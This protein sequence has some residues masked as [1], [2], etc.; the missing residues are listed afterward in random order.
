MDPAGVSREE[1]DD[2]GDRL[3]AHA[4]QL[5]SALRR[6]RARA[7]RA[8]Y[9]PQRHKR[10]LAEFSAASPHLPR[11]MRPMPSKRIFAEIGK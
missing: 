10:L 6:E 1:S 7:G 8:G 4:K 2:R 11:A 9:D 3:V 5:A